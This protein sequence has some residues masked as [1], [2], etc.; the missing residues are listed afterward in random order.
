MRIASGKVVDGKVV[1]EGDSLE[2][3]TLVTVIAPDEA[4][5]FELSSDEEDALRAAI[6]EADRGEGADGDAFLDQL[7]H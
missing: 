1:L 4:N 5:T 6:A 3:G 2:E 7:T